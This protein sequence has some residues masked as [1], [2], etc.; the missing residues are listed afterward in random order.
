MK[1]LLSI[2][3]VGVALVAVCSV[4]LNSCKEAPKQMPVSEYKVIRI[5][6]SDKELSSSYSATFSGKQSVEIRPQ[7]A[8]VIT[9]VCI[10]EGATVKKDQPLFIIDQVPYKAA[11][12]TA[13]ANVA[14]A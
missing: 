13:Q 7:V 11:L 5:A 1:K 2:N 8:G 9:K 14:S 12:Q 10:E 3:C 6:S 4:F